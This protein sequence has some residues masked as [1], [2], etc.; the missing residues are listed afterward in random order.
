MNSQ[1]RVGI[2]VLWAVALVCGVQASLRHSLAAAR[3]AAAQVGKLSAS[4]AEWRRPAGTDDGLDA[5]VQNHHASG[6]VRYVAQ[7]GDD[8][9]QCDSVAERCASVQHALDVAQP[10]DEIRV[11][12]GNYADADG[13]VATVEKTVSLLGGWNSG[14]TSRDPGLYP[15]VLDAEGNGRVVTVN[16]EREISPTIDGFVI[17]GGNAGQEEEFPGRGGGIFSKGSNAR[18]LNNVIVSNVA[19]VSPTNGAGGGICVYGSSAT[20]VIS[21]NQIL[22][23]TAYSDIWGWG[24]GGIHLDEGSALVQ[25]N[26]IEHNRC[27]LNGGGILSKQGKPRMLNNEIRYNEAGRNGGGI[28]SDNH[29]QP[30][31]R[32]NLVIGNVA[33]WNGG[34]IIVSGWV[35]STIDANRLLSNTGYSS[36][37]IAAPH[38]TATNNLI[39][40]SD[41][42]GIS[43]WNTAVS[44]LVA[45]NTLVSNA[46]WGIRLHNASV[47]P[48]IINNI[49]AFNAT[50]IE[51]G[52]Q[53][54]GTLDYNDVWGNTD[55]NYDLPGALQPGPH[56]IESDPL[57][58]NPAADDFHILAGSPCVDAGTDAGVSRDFDG[59]LRPIG[60]GAD[61][62]ADEAHRPIYLPLLLRMGL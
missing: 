22:S 18:I 59:D 36:L 7:D 28:A 51:A 57:F 5:Q 26:L 38:F 61:I 20:A 12:T 48:T 40:H 31:I 53:V 46:R 49:V 9:N 23:N 42:G 56:S 27:N 47:T 8:G 4:A 58:V 43:L 55:Q 32:G 45:H 33:G 41:Y 24:G 16:G 35:T 19:S 37:A 30:L 3:T 29:D 2:S 10:G 11:S 15:T 54:S 14:F 13:T 21:G 52:A 60:S 62:G 39:G 17:R 1:A 44:G 6:V 50:G 25:G 34:G